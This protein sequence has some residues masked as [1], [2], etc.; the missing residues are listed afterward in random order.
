MKNLLLLILLLPCVAAGQVSDSIGH[1]KIISQW[2]QDGAW[3]EVISLA[4]A[5]PA[6]DA[7]LLQSAGFAS[8]QAGDKTASLDFYN[9][10]LAAD[11]NHK[12]ALYYTALIHK[13]DEH[14][15]A[16][17][18]LLQRLCRAAP[19][20]AQYHVLLADCYTVED[21][22]KA[23]VASLQTAR[24]LSPGSAII[25]NKLATAWIRTKQWDSAGQLLNSSLQQHPGDPALISTAI[26][27]AYTRKQ[28]RRASS[29]CDSLIATGQPRYESLLT[30][31]YADISLPDYSHA[32]RLGELL[33]AL[34]KE[35]EEVL[36]YTALAHQHLGHWRQADTLLRKCVANVLKPNL[37]AYYLAL[38]DGAAKQKDW[39]RCKTYYDTAYY[40]FKNPTTL[41]RKALALESSG[42][43]GDAKQAYKR[44]LSLPLAM[45][46]TA[47]AKYLKQK[48]E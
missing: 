38:A 16:A 46:D 1:S 39:A 43:A 28:Y 26:T 11:S 36:Y 47:I 20:S 18:P 30:G 45:Q 48:L 22:S 24:R 12:Q 31:I 27:L 34:G 5:T 8:Y 10:L 32:V 9:R 25:A 40:L 44:Y 37:E 29:L 15:D 23:A 2:L 4:H 21:E 35:T 7:L 14:C 33:S 42:R 13:S 19:A 3:D 17:I 6:P 41:Y